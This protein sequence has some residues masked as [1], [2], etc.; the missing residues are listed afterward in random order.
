MH[1]KECG[2]VFSPKME[3]KFSYFGNYA[4]QYLWWQCM[5]IVECLQYSD[6]VEEE[7]PFPHFDQSITNQYRVMFGSGLN[8]SVHPL[9]CGLKNENY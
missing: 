3:W 4:L 6:G 9:T 5:N 2:T 8:V 7:A 1:M